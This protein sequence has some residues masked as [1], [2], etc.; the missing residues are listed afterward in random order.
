MNFP[1]WDVPVLG[2]G[3]VIGIVATLHVFISHFAIGGGAFLAFTEQLAYKRNDARIYEYLRQHAKFFLL[4][5]TVVGAITGVGIWWAIGLASPSGTQVLLQNFSLYWAAEYLFFAAELVTFFVYY[6]T[7]GRIDK[8]L[9]LQIA[10]IY[11]GISFGTLFVINGILTFMLTSGGWAESGNIWQGYFNPGF[12]PALF[13]RLFI[14][15]ALAGIYALLT[16]SRIKDADLRSYLLKYSSKWMLPAL[17]LGP[18]F[19]VWYLFVL[20]APTQQ[21]IL[22][23]ISSIG[24]GNFS[25]LARALF[26]SVAFAASLLG[27][28]FVGPYLNPRHF[29]FTFALMIFATAFGFMLTEEWSREMM[30]KP[31]VIYN[32]MYSNGLRKTAI[33]DSNRKGFFEVANFA[34]A[35]RRLLP[36]ATPEQE[37]ALLFRYQCMSCHVPGKSGYRAMGRLLGDRD[38]T[39]IYNLLE[40]M[41]TNHQPENPYHGYMPPFVGKQHEQKALA[42]YLATLNRTGKEE[43]AAH[44]VAAV[45]PTAL[46]A[47]SQQQ[48]QPAKAERTSTD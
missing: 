5:T 12:I 17:A 33:D 25:I 6:Y 29:S 27:L 45:Q 23:G 1:V 35:Q 20:P 40:L 4:I 8:K 37:G 2:N 48:Q 30:R 21:V 9:H 13:I 39:A 11:F 32:Y 16:A 38:E 47:Q 43:P 42:K 26:M 46:P 34:E 15:F 31:Y 24:E 28:V 22:N 10:W 19:L 18:L 36:N 14:M 44:P 7:L 41:R 3:W